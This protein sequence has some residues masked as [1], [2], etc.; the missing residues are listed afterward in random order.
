M[1]RL[2]RNNVEYGETFRIRIHREGETIMQKLVTRIHLLLSSETNA[3]SQ[4]PIEE[5][6]TEE[7]GLRA[8]CLWNQVSS[9][10]HLSP[11]AV[12]IRTRCFFA[13]TEPNVSHTLSL[14]RLFRSAIWLIPLLLVLP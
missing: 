10:L 2:E 13:C 5:S 4:V 11:A 6:A 14:M 12:T 9:V 3:S 1:K 8:K 7:Q